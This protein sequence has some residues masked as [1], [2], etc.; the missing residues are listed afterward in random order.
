[1]ESAAHVVVADAVSDEQC[2]PVTSEADAPS[3]T[4]AA[5]VVAPAKLEPAVDAEVS[6]VLAAV[7]SQ[8]SVPVEI[9]GSSSLGQ[10]G[11]AEDVEAMVKSDAAPVLGFGNVDRYHVTFDPAIS[12]DLDVPAVDGEVECVLEDVVTVIVAID[13]FSNAAPFKAKNP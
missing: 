12:A 2:A 6:E 1:V 5:E 4:A 8:L 11:V 10:V 13:D 3:E 7:L 9:K